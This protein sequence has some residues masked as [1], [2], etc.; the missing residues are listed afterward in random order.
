MKKR[1]KPFLILV[2]IAVD[3]FVVNLAGFAA[4]FTRF[5][6]DYFVL[7]ASGF[8]DNFKSLMLFSTVVTIVIFALFRLYSTVWAYAGVGELLR[9]ISACIL[10]VSAEMIYAFAFHIRMPRSYMLMK[11]LFFIAAVCVIRFANRIA[12]M[13][14]S[15]TL[16]KQKRT[17]LI[18]AG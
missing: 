5:E 16:K 13:L 15:T 3:A 1:V 6:F 14:T 2:M 17:M 11:L 18:G 8:L 9:I 7:V 12:R 10:S 4:L